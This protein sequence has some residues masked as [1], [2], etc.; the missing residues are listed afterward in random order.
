MMKKQ[1]KSITKVD[2]SNQCHRCKK[3]YLDK[4]VAILKEGAVCFNCI[5][6]A[7]PYWRNRLLET[8]SFTN[9][10]IE[11][12]FNIQYNQKIINIVN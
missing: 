10:D 7:L 9:K 8:G 5:D 3:F 11:K 1:F 2:F 4:D 12:L 6:L